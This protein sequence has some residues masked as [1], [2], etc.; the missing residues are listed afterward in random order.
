MKT[1]HFYAIIIGSEILNGRRIDKHF[2]FVRDALLARGHV[3][4]ASLIIKDD[5]ALIRTVFGMVK[6]DPGTGM[7][8]FCW[9]VL[10]QV[11]MVICCSGPGKS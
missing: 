10:G 2:D 7:Y 3:L 5:P 1:P 11:R 8:S 4:Y 9:I 6:S